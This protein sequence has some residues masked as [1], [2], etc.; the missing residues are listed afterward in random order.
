MRYEGHDFLKNTVF[1]LLVQRQ[2]ELT[3]HTT[4]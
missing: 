4:V 1:N 3:T 2:Q